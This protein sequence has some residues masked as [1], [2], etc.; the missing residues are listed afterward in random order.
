MREAILRAL[1][2]TGPSLAVAQEGTSMPER[3]RAEFSY[4]CN[5]TTLCAQDGACST[6][7][8]VVTFKLQEIDTQIHGEGTYQFSYLGLSTLARMDNQYGPYMWVNDEYNIQ[9][10]Q[11]IGGTETVSNV[12]YYATWTQRSAYGRSPSTVRFLTCVDQ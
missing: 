11:F 5:V 12:I 10:L 3:L 7:S 2:A 9:M 1:I 8:D 6:V 4:E